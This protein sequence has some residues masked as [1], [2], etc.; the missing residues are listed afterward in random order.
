MRCIQPEPYQ[1]PEHHYAKPSQNDERPGK[2]LAEVR[3]RYVNAPNPP[4]WAQV[5][6]RALA[7]S[8][9]SG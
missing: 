9:S 5:L 1:A 7:A 2:A 8:N 3:S 6:P 4:G